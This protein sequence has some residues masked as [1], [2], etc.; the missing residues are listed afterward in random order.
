MLQKFRKLVEFWW[1]SESMV[2]WL[3]QDVVSAL[4]QIV[5]SISRIRSYNI[6]DELRKYDLEF[7]TS[8]WDYNLSPACKVPHSSRRLLFGLSSKYLVM[9]DPGRSNYEST[10]SK[11][12]TVD[13]VSKPTSRNLDTKRTAIAPESLKWVIKNALVTPH[14][15]AGSNPLGARNSQ[16]VRRFSETP[17]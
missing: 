7:D 1:T 14:F 12:S 16:L 3:M 2:H 5:R 15:T 9:A 17:S 4:I 10:G 13:Q 6:E 11:S 8:K